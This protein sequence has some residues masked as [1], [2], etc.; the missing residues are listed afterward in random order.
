MVSE[1]IKIEFKDPWRMIPLENAGE[2][3][4]QVRNSLKPS[5]PLYG[6]DIFVSGRHETKQLLLIDNDTDDDYAIV[7]FDIDSRSKDITCNTVET[8]SSRLELA[9]KL[10]HDH[11]AAQQ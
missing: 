3:I 1:P 10:L 2:W 4:D 9:N 7:S 5:D 6:K 8:I 11:E